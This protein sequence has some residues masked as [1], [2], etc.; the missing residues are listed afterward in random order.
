MEYDGHPPPLGLRQQNS[1]EVMF[2][3]LTAMVL[4]GYNGGFLGDPGGAPLP[5]WFS[6]E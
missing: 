4:W 2:S 1:Y 3:S 5:S 6:H